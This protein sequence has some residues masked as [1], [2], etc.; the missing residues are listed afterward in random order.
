MSSAGGGEFLDRPDQVVAP[1]AAEA[2]GPEAERLVGVGD[3][4]AAEQHGGTG[5]CRCADGR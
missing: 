2:V 5:K 3:G 1:P 4:G